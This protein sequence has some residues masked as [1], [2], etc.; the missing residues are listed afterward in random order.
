VIVVDT[1]DHDPRQREGRIRP[2]KASITERNRVARQLGRQVVKVF[3]TIHAGHLLTRTG[4]IDRL[5]W[6]GS[7]PDG[8][9]IA[10]CPEERLRC[11]LGRVDGF[12][13]DQ[14]ACGTDDG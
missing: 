1:C 8:P 12:H 4:S 3:N 11:L 6:I 2:I 5:A 9:T 13:Q 14:A 7:L 10:E